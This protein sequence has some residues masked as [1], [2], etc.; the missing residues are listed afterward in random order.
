MTFLD[1]SRLDSFDEAEA[2]QYESVVEYLVEIGAEP[3]AD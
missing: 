1:V 2:L 3:G